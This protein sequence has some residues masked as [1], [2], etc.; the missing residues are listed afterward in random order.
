MGQYSRLGKNTILVFAGNAG[1]KLIGLLMLP[2]Y[3]RWLDADEYGLTDV[4]SI[5]VTF[6]IS[7]VTCCI[8]ES[9]FIFPKGESKKRQT[10]L[11][12]SAILF[13][14]FT[15]ITTAVIF[16][17]VKSVAL[18]YD[19]H[20]SFV[21]N[22]WLIF[23]MML[24]QITQQITQQFARSLDKMMI[25]SGSGVVVTAG[26]ALFAFLLIPHYGVEGYVW[27]MIFAYLCGA[28]FSLIASFQFRYIS[29]VSIDKESCVE[30]LKYSI[31]LIPNA[32]M[33]WL[34][35]ALNRPI[36]EFHCG[37]HDI[38]LF[39]VANKFPGILSMVFA[40]F[41][42]SWQIS[43]LEEYGKPTFQKFYNNVMRIIF[44]CLSIV[45]IV[46]SISS[47]LLVTM[48][49]SASFYDAWQYVPL[50][51]LGML[52]TNLS[53]F[54][55]T[56]FSAVRKSKYF[57]YSSVWGAVGAV[58]FNFLLIPSLKLWGAAISFLLSFAVMAV[59]RMFYARRYIKVTDIHV[60]GIMIL[61]DIMM[62][63]VMSMGVDIIYPVIFG[64]VA[65][66]IDLYMS[67]S[68]IRD[69]ISGYF[70]NVIKDR[71][72]KPV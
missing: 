17:G 71:R 12:S 8:C 44:T 59:S 32:I 18:L 55:G 70:I 58:F 21:D 10:E 64:I 25:Y 52:F 61:L 41:V 26:T 9:I 19:W 54:S 53:G 38:G 11:F 39:A 46:I 33:W 42:T 72:D 2:F 4:I 30:M 51:T 49:A 5:Y 68:M 62:I 60:Y 1:A 45:L 35:S 23:F 57:F 13:V 27:S 56:V 69:F 37:L 66:A 20:N 47:K 24:S 14:T 22:V 6:L 29:F 16:F 65:I 15:C 40:I 3:T 67:R 31:P 36:M 34:V 43:V 50:L 48:F 63:V 7:I 28:L